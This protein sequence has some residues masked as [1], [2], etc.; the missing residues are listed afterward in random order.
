[1]TLLGFL[2]AQALSQFSIIPWRFG[3]I[4]LDIISFGVTALR[5]SD[6]EPAEYRV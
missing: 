2:L 4:P 6:V 5:D 1:M 3:A